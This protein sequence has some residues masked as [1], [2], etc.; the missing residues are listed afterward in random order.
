[1]IYVC[2]YPGKL[3]TMA[4]TQM[5]NNM[6]IGDIP[7]WLQDSIFFENISEGCE[8]DSEFTIDPCFIRDTPDINNLEDF[9]SVIRVMSYWNVNR[10]P[11]SVKKALES[12]LISYCEFNMVREEFPTFGIEN[13]AILEVFANQFVGDINDF[14]KAVL[15]V[16]HFD[17]QD[18]VPRFIYDFVANKYYD[19]E[20]F[21]ETIKVSVFRL[22]NLDRLW[23]KMMII[24]LNSTTESILRFVQQG[25]EE[26]PYDALDYLCSIASDFERRSIYSEVH[27]KCTDRRSLEIL[28]R[29]GITL[30]FENTYSY[31]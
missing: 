5:E 25:P 7:L 12:N 13:W 14:E 16:S 20:R 15:A 11:I 9:V 30:Q 18:S 4:M 29:H 26:I 22:C 6:T 1:M 2:L 17:I 8:L 28:H 21:S 10:I 3:G 31:Y 27:E 24:S 23:K 19:I